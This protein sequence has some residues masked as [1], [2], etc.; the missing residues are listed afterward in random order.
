M[1]KTG[2]KKKERKEERKNSSKGIVNRT[3]NA[4]RA[5]VGG[6]RRGTGRATF[7]ASRKVPPISPGFLRFP[8]CAAQVGSTRFSHARRLSKVGRVS[9]ARAR[10]VPPRGRGR[11][12]VSRRRDHGEREEGRGGTFRGER[13]GGRGR[14]LR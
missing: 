5:Q 3:S 6:A 2:G 12:L 8:R 13:R 14:S 9:A 7:P 10:S 1:Q 11:A 4:R